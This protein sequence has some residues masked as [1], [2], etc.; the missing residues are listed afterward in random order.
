L[1]AWPENEPV[2]RLRLTIIAFALLLLTGLAAAA[3]Q[4]PGKLAR[5]SATVEQLEGQTLTAKTAT[6]K[7]LSLALSP[8]VLVLRSKPA[9]L[10]DV[11]SGEFI[12]CTAVE[13]DDGKLQAKEIHI[14]PE[15][16]RGVGEG[17]YPWGNT[18]KTTMTNGNIE[19]VAGVTDGHVIKVSYH[20]GQSAID[21]PA[22]VT[23]TSIE[24][25]SRDLLKPG[26]KI[27]L[28]AH[29]N[30][31]GSLTPQFIAIAP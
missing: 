6:G 8:G 22:G 21:I 27:N 31:D 29:K 30:P 20:G 12:G 14:L 4:P 16:M 1:A 25:V 15:S 10:A 5:M 23:V 13:G 28:F 24:V 26:T 2:T 7:D 3:D 19:Q 11:K 9:T 18:P 17:H